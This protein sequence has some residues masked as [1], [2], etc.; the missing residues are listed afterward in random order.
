MAVATGLPFTAQHWS[1]RAWV[2]T[3]MTG[4]SD[5]VPVLPSR[6]TLSS[7]AGS[8]TEP[9]RTDSRPGLVSTTAQRHSHCARRASARRLALRMAKES[10]N[11]AL[12]TPLSEGL[13]VEKRNFSLLFATV[14]QKE[15]MT[16]FLE[17]RKP[18]FKGR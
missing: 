15:G 13:R 3:Q 4:W 14:D 9:Q 12:E 18:Q 17:R 1:C 7:P 11:R 8:C 5:G 16:A 10:V 6:G 2:H